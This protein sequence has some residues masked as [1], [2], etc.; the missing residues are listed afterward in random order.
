MNFRIQRGE[1]FVYYQSL[2][3]SIEE[4]LTTF[5]IARLYRK[6]VNSYEAFVPLLEY[7]QPHD[8]KDC[9]LRLELNFISLL[10]QPSG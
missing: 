3:T 8:I 2:K 10:S 6:S 1:D 4:A 7:G 5:V 9:C